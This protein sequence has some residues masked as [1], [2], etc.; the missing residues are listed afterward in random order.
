MA[1]A[2]ME[3]EYDPHVESITTCRE[4]N[5][6]C[7]VVGIIHLPPAIH[8]FNAQLSVDCDTIAAMAAEKE[9]DRLSI[10]DTR[11]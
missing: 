11:S 2:S 6:T 7:S 10:V 4:Q 1:T 3:V 5:L 9:T 8:C